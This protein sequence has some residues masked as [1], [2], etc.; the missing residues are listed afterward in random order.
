MPALDLISIMPDVADFEEATYRAGVYTPRHHIQDVL[1]VVFKHLGKVAG[2][3]ALTKGIKHSRLVP[4]P[5][6]NM[7][8]TALFDTFDYNAVEQAVKKI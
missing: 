2:R 5:D 7:R 4:D 6:G 1:G 3:K 8:D